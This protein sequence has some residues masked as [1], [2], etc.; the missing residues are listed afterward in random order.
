[1]LGRAAPGGS[2]PGR[3]CCRSGPARFAPA[4]QFDCTALRL[5]SGSVKVLRLPVALPTPGTPL[6]LRPLHAGAAGA[7]A[8]ARLARGVLGRTGWYGVAGRARVLRRAA[9]IF[10]GHSWAFVAGIGWAA[11]AAGRR[12]PVTRSAESFDEAL[13]VSGQFR[14]TR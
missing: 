6:R 5:P 4:T 13:G 2:V 8:D 9:L 10:S 12:M 7:D 3:V 14:T 11:G 1:M